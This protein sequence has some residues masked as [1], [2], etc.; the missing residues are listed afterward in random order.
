M[1]GQMLQFFSF[2]KKYYQ[3]VYDP[4]GID[5][6]GAQRPN[7]IALVTWLLTLAWVSLVGENCFI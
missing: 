4:A 1:Y 2:L 3:Q 5:W 7:G 6:G